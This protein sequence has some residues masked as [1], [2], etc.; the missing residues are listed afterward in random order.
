[1]DLDG[2]CA[3]T[4]ADHRRRVAAAGRWHDVAMSPK[5]RKG[6]QRPGWR[7]LVASRLRHNADR[8]EPGPSTPRVALLRAVAH[9]ELTIDQ[10]LL[11]LSSEVR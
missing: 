10:A 6:L 11:L 2:I 8:I 4:L 7:N 5:P 3:Q 1:M 9:R